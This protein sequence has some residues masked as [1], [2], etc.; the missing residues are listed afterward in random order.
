MVVLSDIRKKSKESLN[1]PKMNL[2]VTFIFE[3]G[4]PSSH[5]AAEDDL[6]FPVSVTQVLGL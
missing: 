3:S 2:T 5:H 4:Y 1:V 6:E